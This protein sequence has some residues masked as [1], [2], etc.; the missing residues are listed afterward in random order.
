MRVARLKNDVL[1]GTLDVPDK[2]DYLD[3]APEDIHLPVE[4]D[5]YSKA[6]S[7]Y[8]TETGNTLSLPTQSLNSCSAYAAGDVKTLTNLMNRAQV[9][10]FNPELQWSHQEDE[11]GANRSSGGTLQGALRMLTK[12]GQGFPIKEYRRV[13]GDITHI[14]TRLAQ[15]LPL[16]TGIYWK[17]SPEGGSNYSKML[18]TGVYEW[19]PTNTLGGHAV[20]VVGYNDTTQMFKCV[21]PMRKSWGANPPGVF[22]VPYSLVFNMYTLYLLKDNLDA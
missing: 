7:F 3:G 18:Q 19:Y 11:A 4:V 16:Y 22:Y 21:E 15:G 9:I 12:Y 2:R 10:S 6:R 5:L 8:V 1:T 13:N 17:R 14:K 20:T